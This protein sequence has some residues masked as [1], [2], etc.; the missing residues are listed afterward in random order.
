MGMRY[1]ISPRSGSGT[2][3]G[4]RYRCHAKG[5]RQKQKA[6]GR[7]KSKPKKTNRKSL[8]DPSGGR[9]VQRPKKNQGQ[10]YFVDIFCGVFELPSPQAS[11][12]NAQKRDKTKPRKKSV[13]DLDFCRIFCYV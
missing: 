10:I 7:P 6:K 3:T 4:M 2:G 13:L 12:R 8:G 5:K 11:P 1:A 9:V